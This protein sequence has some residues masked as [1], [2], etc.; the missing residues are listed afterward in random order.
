MEYTK[1]TYYS[2]IEPTL[3]DKIT[4]NNEMYVVVVDTRAMSPSEIDGYEEH[5][6]THQFFKENIFERPN[7]KWTRSK[8]A[9]LCGMNMKIFFHDYVK[10]RPRVLRESPELAIKL[11]E[12]ELNPMNK[13]NGAATLLTFDPRTGCPEYT[14]MG[15]AFVV[16]DSGDYPLSDHQVWGIQDL[17]SE[18]RDLYHCDP[19]HLHRGHRQLVRWCEAYRKREWG[20]LTIYEPRPIFTR[21]DPTYQKTVTFKDVDEYV[22]GRMEA[23]DQ[24]EYYSHRH[25]PNC[26]CEYCKSPRFGSSDDEHDENQHDYRLYRSPSQAS[27]GTGK[28]L[29]L[30]VYKSRGMMCRF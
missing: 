7:I 14:V 19:E 24:H 29:P 23:Q 27:H 18:A 6:C 1:H 30:S 12:K 8:V 13:V 4:M 17:I 3:F 9:V 10:N 16:V 25:F 26:A 22:H 11:E 2:K 5:R 28:R 20:P 15:K 21:R